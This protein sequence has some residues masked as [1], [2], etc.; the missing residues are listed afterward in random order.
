MGVI[1]TL[2]P[3]IKALT[4]QIF[5]DVITEL[6]KPC[7]LVYP[8]KMVSC[9]NCNGLSSSGRWKTGGPMPFSVGLC[10]LCN[11]RNKIAEEVFES[12]NFLCQFE[13]K[14]FYYPV[15]EV[16]IRT[17]LNYI[18]IKGYLK[19]VPKIKRVDHIIIETPIEG[20]IQWRGKLFDEPMD[21]S[22]IIQG[23]YFTCTL[24]RV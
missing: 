8:P 9:S 1:F 15:D 23:R 10:P 19:D 13:K 22:N 20:I 6:S 12:I 5:D 4:Q 16:D 18:Q 14:N 17:P 21:R 2:T 11:G 7:R 24:K 3:D